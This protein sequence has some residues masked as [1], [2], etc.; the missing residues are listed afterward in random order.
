MAA[1][2]VLP[3]EICFKEAVI[4]A[5][6]IKSMITDTRSQAAWNIAERRCA[7]EKI[8][9]NEQEQI[10]EGAENAYFGRNGPAKVERVVWILSLNTFYGFMLKE[11]Y[12]T[13]DEILGG[14]TYQ[15]LARYL[16]KNYKQQIHEGLVAEAFDLL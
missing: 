11:I 10:K 1:S 5:R 9:E 13:V 4:A 6:L 8:T 16:I 7:G 2:R 12:Q 14:S 15:D 3:E